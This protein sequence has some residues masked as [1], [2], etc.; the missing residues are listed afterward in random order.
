MAKQVIHTDAAPKAIGT[1]SQAVRVGNTVYLSGQI[2]LG[3]DRKPPADVSAEA[4][5]V[6]EAVKKEHPGKVDVPADRV[7]SGL[8]AYKTALATDADLLHTEAGGSLAA[9]DPGAVSERARQRGRWQ[10]LWLLPVTQVI[11]C[12]LHGGFFVGILL[13]LAYAVGEAVGWL[14]EPEEEAR[15]GAARRLKAY[16]LAAG[17]CLARIVGDEAIRV[18]S[19]HRQ[20]IGRLAE[21]VETSADIL[22]GRRVER[23]SRH[24][25]KRSSA[26]WS[27]RWSTSSGAS[28]EATRSFRPSMSFTSSTGCGPSSPPASGGTSRR[29]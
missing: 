19:L 18:N 9:A 6:M 24:S 3:P 28:S 27:R 7:F 8:D 14:V 23:A 29:T 12:N 16:A 2:G 13:A 25:P 11:W 4:K 5:L 10:G 21:V 26:I 15:R 20:A 1:Y 17:G 22:D